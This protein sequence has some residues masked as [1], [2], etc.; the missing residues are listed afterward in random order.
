MKVL[1]YSLFPLN[2]FGG[3]E[4]YSINSALSIAHAG[5]TVDLYCP[6]SQF[7]D[8]ILHY[9]SIKGNQITS[10]IINGEIDTKR[11][12]SFQELVNKI[13]EYDI[14]WFHQYLSNCGIY[15][16]LAVTTSDQ[17]VFFTSLGHESIKKQFIDIYQPS[18]RH[19]FI[20]I[21]PAAAKRT[22]AAFPASKNIIS[23]SGGLWEDEIISETFRSQKTYRSHEVISVGRVLPHKGF[24]STIGALPD[25]CKLTIVGPVNKQSDYYQHLKSLSADK[26]IF[27]TDKISN[28]EKIQR[29]SEADILVAA[30]TCKLY[31]GV[32]IDQAELLGLVLLEAVA[33]N[34]LP[35]ASDIPS[36]RDI[37][38][39]L[40]LEEFVF[41]QSDVGDI[42]K[43]IQK[44]LA[45]NQEK[46]H[47]LLRIA[48]YK[49][50]EKYRWENYWERIL[51]SVKA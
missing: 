37:M 34:V 49:L 51:T 47:E 48:K 20:E 50:F 22:K 2:S 25:N 10:V 45:L 29:I 12:I 15:P 11:K 1:I 5:D 35:V 36:Y 46:K 26:N 13:S 18:P 16:L 6:E 40:G 43:I 17:K 14:I 39:D 4:F 23:L 41:K 24:E 8:D 38:I 33:I 9:N 28:I 32:T 21:S 30:S 42:R 7:E 44:A 31:N 19:F 3:G 27:F